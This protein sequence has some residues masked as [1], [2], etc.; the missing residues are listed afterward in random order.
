MSRSFACS[1][2]YHAAQRGIQPSVR[3]RGHAI[4]R[5]EKA[6]PKDRIV[7]DPTAALAKMPFEE[8]MAELEK[9]VD[10][11]EKGSVPLEKSIEIYERGE[12]LKAHCDRL[13]KSAE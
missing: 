2:S 11:L 4:E 9:I 1:R 3:R 13:L 12:Q 7:T 6:F 8:A 10:Q 5:R